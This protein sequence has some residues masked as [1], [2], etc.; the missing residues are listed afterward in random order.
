MTRSGGGVLVR[1]FPRISSLGSH[2]RGDLGRPLQL[3]P[4]PISLGSG[5]R[6]LRLRGSGDR[7]RRRPGPPLLGGGT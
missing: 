7:L 1:M 4:A 2:L 3:S 6:D 5:L